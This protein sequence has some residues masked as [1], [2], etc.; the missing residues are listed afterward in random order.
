MVMTSILDFD[1]NL[2]TQG[3][4]H[5][6]PHVEIAYKIYI[7]HMVLNKFNKV[8][9]ENGF[10]CESHFRLNVSTA[11]NANVDLESQNKHRK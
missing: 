8:L 7:I 3:H 2:E 4:S 6:I 1:L 9:V 11:V 5:L 10:Q